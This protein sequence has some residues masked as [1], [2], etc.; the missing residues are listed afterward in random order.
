MLTAAAPLVAHGG[1]YIGP[2]DVVPPGGG[3]AAPPTPS[4][5]P[6]PARPATPPTPSD[7]ATPL[8]PAR[9]VT[10]PQPANG[11]KPGITSGGA[12]G[13]DLSTWVF[14]WEFN[15]DRFLNL[16]SK[17]AEIAI[18][19]EGAGPLLGLGAGAGRIPSLLPTM[20]QK[21]N[22]IVPELLRLLSEEENTDIATAS[23]IALAKVGIQVEN[24]EAAFTRLLDAPS[25]EVRETAA[26]SLG[27]LKD[28]RALPLLESLLADDQDGRKVT[29][30]SEV[31]PRT[32][33][34]AAYGLAMVGHETKEQM[35]KERVAETLY[36]TLVEDASAIKDIRVACVVG[37]GVLELKD[38]SLMVHRLGGILDEDR[39]SPL[40]LAHIPNAMAKL[41]RTL[42]G[43]H[44]ERDAAID[45]FL[46][47]LAP[48]S[49]RSAF[50]KMS[51]VQ[52]LGMAAVADD[53]RNS[54]IFDT[55]VR[56]SKKA[57]N[58]QV[59]NFTAISMAYLGVA[60]PAL[61]PKTIRF[62][63]GKM[64]KSST[65]YRQWS[66]L[67]LGVMAYLLDKKGAAMPQTTMDVTLS[68]FRDAKSPEE[69][70]A[71]AIAL[72]LMRYAP[73]KE[74]LLHSLME[75]RDTQFRGYAAL[76]LGMLDAREYGKDLSVLVGQSQRKP[77]LLRQA[78]IGLGLMKDRN[79]LSLLLGYLEPESGRRPRLAVLSSVATAI[80]F[81]GDKASV[82]PLIDTMGNDRLTPLGRAFAAVALGMVAD[83]DLLPW[84]SMFSGDL[85]YRASVS[86]L[87]DQ[88]TGTGI[89]D[90]R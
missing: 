56:Q 85:N 10:P 4:T 47:I 78:S 49:K 45:R 66:G 11:A 72:G 61:R 88:A 50:L 38:P 6:D 58:V 70:S 55:L 15:K 22:I 7:P 79:A 80:G 21:K 20:R 24:C 63:S 48:R 12:I 43:A 83:K 41:M 28:E 74:H 1:V 84:N 35:V 65:S 18:A 77:D 68:R 69:K 67:S 23:M 31:P 73:A 19:T 27:I 71:Y 14:W 3:D 16:R 64:R 26:L 34:F 90:I 9:P 25:Q 62:L 30:G 82:T 2:G 40:V 76:A 39:M 42:P 44:P 87:V 53:P 46:A 37:L 81:I 36:R 89:L 60:D 33:T 86:T 13:S 5:P 54:E 32:R 59:K 52:A 29:G 51:A 8:D 57:K 75:S 17:V